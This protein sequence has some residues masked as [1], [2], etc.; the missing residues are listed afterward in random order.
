MA[1]PKGSKNSM[2]K[3][4]YEAFVKE[5]QTKIDELQAK[6]N[7]YRQTVNDFVDGFIMELQDNVKKIKLS[8]LQE[9]FS[10]PDEYMEKINNLLTYYYIIDGSVSQLYD[11]F[12]SLPELN[13]TIKCYEKTDSYNEDIIKIKKY[14]DK[15][16]NH[17]KLTR[18]LLI[19]LSH[20]G[21]VLG[22]WLGNKKEP[23]FHVFNN[24]KYIYPY[25]IYKNNMVGVY[26]LDYIDTLTEEQKKAEFNTL[27][28]FINQKVYNKWKNCSDSNKARELQ[29]VVLPPEKS[30]VARIRTLSRNQRLGLPYGTSAIVDLQHKQKLKD[31]E[32]T[33]ADKIMRALAVVKFTSK[34]SNDKVVKESVQKRVFK[35]VKQ[36]LEQSTSENAIT[37]IGLPDFAKFE[38]PEIKGGEDILKPD[39]YNSI[40]NDITTSTG[41][42]SV[43]SNGTGG[44]YA[45]AGMSLDMIYKKLG[46]ALEQIEVI[47]NQLIVILLGKKKGNNYHFEYIKDTPLSKKD[48]LATLQKLSDK[49]YAIRPLL[50]MV[51]VDF[52]SYIEESTYEIE[53]LK[54]RERIIP[55]LTSN[56][57]SSSDINNGGRPT[58]DDSINDST[59]SSKGQNGNGNPKPSTS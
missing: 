10:N 34:D 29:L 27:N 25:G 18:D 40:N 57:V 52:E 15:N 38:Y 5:M 28:P 35:G 41:I 54:L 12:Y 44:N 42:S 8:T 59:I 56:T 48:K 16:I 36:V 21:T 13:Y 31:L 53:V 7:D 58:K 47:Y 39:K 4:D 22:T 3:T 33:M 55:S 6:N 14:L 23:Y 30:L 26:D 32:R 46:G 37:V 45:S 50:E 19:Q 17:K 2:T 24:L 20:E 49:G 1:R 43:L 9:W 11:L 51:G